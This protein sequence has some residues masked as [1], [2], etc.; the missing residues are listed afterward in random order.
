[1]A[2]PGFVREEPDSA[3]VLAAQLGVTLRRPK[4]MF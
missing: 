2:L 1:M 4:K 3:C